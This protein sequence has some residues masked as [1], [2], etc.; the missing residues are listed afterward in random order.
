MRKLDFVV[1]AFSYNDD[2]PHYV[3]KYNNHFHTNGTFESAF[4]F[5]TEDAAK[6]AIDEIKK[7]TLP[8][9]GFKD[10]YIIMTETVVTVRSFVEHISFD[11][12]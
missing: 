8:A 7:G 6:A 2:A 9:C 3:A 4:H 11:F 10:W 5:E 1:K 12:F